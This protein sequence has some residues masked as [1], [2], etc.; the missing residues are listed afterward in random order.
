MDL[1]SLIFSKFSRKLHEKEL[2]SKDELISLD[3]I[4]ILPLLQDATN[5]TLRSETLWRNCV[6]CINHKRGC[7]KPSKKV[8]TICGGG[9]IKNGSYF[10]CVCDAGYT[11]N[12]FELS[13]MRQNNRNGQPYQCVCDIRHIV[14]S[15]ELFAIR[16]CNINGLSDQGVCDIGHTVHS[17]DL[18]PISECN[19]NGST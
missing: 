7:K 2:P 8:Q 19:R 10:S 17:D 12:P 3:Y 14:L 5:A 9:C 16:E 6:W 11:V 1:M 18:F 4:A 13:A 15:N